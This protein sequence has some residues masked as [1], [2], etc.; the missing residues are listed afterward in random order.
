LPRTRIADPFVIIPLWLVER[1]SP[2]ALKLYAV[3]YAH[4]AYQNPRK[5]ISKAE[6]IGTSTS[7]LSWRPS[8]WK[9]VVTGEPP[10]PTSS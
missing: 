1:A 5:T 7:S 3:L 6:S 2:E 8:R 10:T 9:A 4:E